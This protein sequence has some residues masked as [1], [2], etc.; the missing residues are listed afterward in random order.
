MGRIGEQ[1]LE[2]VL[3]Y[4]DIAT[5]ADKRRLIEMAV[6]GKDWTREG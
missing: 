5:V 6:D 2:K 4:Q 3:T 1:I